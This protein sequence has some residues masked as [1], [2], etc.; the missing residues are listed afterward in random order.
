[1]FG[2]AHYDHCSAIR[3]RPIPLTAGQHATSNTRPGKISALLGQVDILVS[4]RAAKHARGMKWRLMTAAFS[5]RPVALYNALLVLLGPIWE[6][7][8]FQV[9]K[10]EIRIPLPPPCEHPSR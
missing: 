4:G 2:P 9:L 6:L 1:V 8:P 3:E 10:A 5:I 7:T